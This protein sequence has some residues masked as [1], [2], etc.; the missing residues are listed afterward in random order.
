MLEY[1]GVK[2]GKYFVVQ[3][4]HDFDTFYAQLEKQKTISVDTETSGLDWVRSETCG[5][6]FGWD[7]EHNYYLPIRHKTNEPQLDND[8]IKEPLKA[9]LE[10]ESVGTSLR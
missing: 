9:V 6:V 5:Y 3:D 10:D 7:I 2:G 1:Q 4:M 8:E